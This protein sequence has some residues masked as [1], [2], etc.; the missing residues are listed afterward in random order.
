MVSIVSYSRLS[1]MII[2]PWT[3]FHIYL[4][5][6]QMCLKCESASRRFQPGEGPSRGLLRDCTT[7][8]IN[9]LQHYRF[10]CR[11]EQIFALHS[12]LPHCILGTDP[13]AA[14]GAWTVKYT[15]NNNNY[16]KDIMYIEHIHHALLLLMSSK[17]LPIS[18]QPKNI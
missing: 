11:P 18:N 6:G 13:A 15:S 17:S 3:Q 5:W 7:S 4:P 12:A 8:P 1:L 14:A 9:S 16:N 2:A 10:N